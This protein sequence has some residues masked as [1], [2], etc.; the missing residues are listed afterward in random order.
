M[1]SPVGLWGKKL[2]VLIEDKKD[3]DTGFMR[4]FSDNYIPV[5][6]ENGNSSLVNRVLNVIPD[7]S[8]DGK[9]CGRITTDDR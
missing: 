3:K 4:G 8:L 2:S 6:I 7:Y 5:V 1:P 9:L